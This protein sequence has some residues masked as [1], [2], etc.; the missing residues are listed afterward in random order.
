MNSLKEAFDALVAQDQVKIAEARASQQF[1]TDVSG[2]D[3]ELIKQAQDYDHIGRVMAHHAFADLVKEALD[4]EMPGAPEEEKKEELAKILAKAR[5]EAPE[6]EK[7]KDEDEEE[8]EEEGEG[9]PEEKKAHVKRAILQKMASD[10]EY[11][12]YLATKYLEG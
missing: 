11:A 9:E 1:G 3:A 5:G 10:P 12:A 6:G 2:A 7:K 8:E 4:E